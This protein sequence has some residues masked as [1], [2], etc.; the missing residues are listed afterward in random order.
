M[1]VIL[2]NCVTLGMYQPCVDEVC[3]TNRCKILQVMDDAIYIFFAVE[4]TIKLVAMGWKGKGA[5][6]ADS[7]NRL[8][9]FIVAAGGAEYFLVMENM[10]LSAIRTIRV[11]RP[12]RA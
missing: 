10:N 7:W 11:L 3:S 12:L 9:F 5:Y 6:M 8:D 2:V 1:L 4:M